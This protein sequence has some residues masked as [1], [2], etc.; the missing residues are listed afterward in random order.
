MGAD[1]C[2]AVDF[3]DDAAAAMRERAAIRDL[4]GGEMSMPRCVEMFNALYGHRGIE[5]TEEMG[6]MFM[7]LLKIVRSSA[8]QTCLDDYVDGC[9]Y[10]AFAGG[11]AARGRG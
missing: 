8:G 1:G 9:A 11:A 3:L 5:L 10:L 2:E 6:W 7:V 4:P